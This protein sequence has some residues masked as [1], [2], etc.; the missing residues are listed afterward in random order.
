MR[1]ENREN[2]PTQTDT[3]LS[4]SSRQAVV[5]PTHTKTLGKWHPFAKLQHFRLQD[6]QQRRIAGWFIRFIAAMVIL[7][8]VARGAAAATLPMV[9][10]ISP[11][12]GEITQE[13]SGNGTVKTREAL[14]ITVP[15]GLPIESILVTP[16]QKV[17][18][19]TPLVRF[20]PEKV[21]E[22]LA[23]E[24]A[25]LDR[26]NQEV[27]VLER[28][29]SH[30]NSALV[31][32]QA[33]LENARQ[34]AAQTRQNLQRNIDTASQELTDSQNKQNS[35]QGALDALA[36]DAPAEERQALEEALTLAKEQVKL[37]ED[38]LSSA[39]Y[40]Y[41]TGTASADREVE[42]A[43]RRLTA[44]Q[45]SDNKAQQQ[46]SDTN[47]A[48]RIKAESLRLDIETQ[49]KKIQALE[50]IK[51]QDF[52]LTATVAGQVTETNPVPTQ[53]QPAVKISTAS[54]GFQAEALLNKKD[55]QKVEVGQKADISDGQQYFANTS[56]GVVESLSDPDSEGNV[57]AILR[58]EGDN[59]KENQSVQISI[60]QSKQEYDQTIPL[61][62]L[63][64][65][66]SSYYV[67]V[68]ETQTGVMGVENI[69][70]SIPVEVKAS[71][72]KNAAI[73]GTLAPDA[74][75]ISDSN[76]PVSDGDR[77]RMASQ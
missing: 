63:R 52:Q 6:P 61:T 38:K 18:V 4:S 67:L 60:V 55:A 70:R 75:I 73:E 46:Q 26:L 7:T 31:E 40:E 54:G 66:K 43:S 11:Q 21:E 77:V 37:A 74:K 24:R 51:S 2:L 15:E 30:D 41:Q 35:A 27:G 33:A 53:D 16:G 44:A 10:T 64:E 25:E 59:W 39:Q 34:T 1:Q 72:S 3:A 22:K 45:T 20:S 50:T 5:E 58:L 48:N 47:A 62:A 13:V 19:G 71:D 9:N 32:A 56:T 49:N 23:R 57:K 28:G 68:V 17:D 14:P 42:S 36:P 12:K 29:E 69:A 8:L 76:K 65:D